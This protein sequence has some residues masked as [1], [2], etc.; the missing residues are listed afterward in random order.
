MCKNTSEPKEMVF[1]DEDNLLGVDNSKYN[2]LESLWD[3]LIIIWFDCHFKQ[4]LSKEVNKILS[5]PPGQRWQI[6]PRFYH[7]KHPIHVRNEI[8][9]FTSSVTPAEFTMT[10]MA[11]EPFFIHVLTLIYTFSW[12]CSVYLG[13]GFQ[14][15]FWVMIQNKQT[16]LPRQLNYIT[17]SQN[18]YC[19]SKE[20]H[21]SW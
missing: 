1:T 20:T 3:D 15:S 21:P 14:V 4:K 5:S 17:N 19:L 6:T 2:S 18:K 8:F 13:L 9:R 11:A 16:K 10:S 12:T 7:H